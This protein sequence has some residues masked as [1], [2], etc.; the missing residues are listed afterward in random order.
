[1]KHNLMSQIADRGQELHIAVRA[2]GRR[3]GRG[4]SRRARSREEICINA[5]CSPRANAPSDQL[6]RDGRLPGT[7]APTLDTQGQER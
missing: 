3:I 4:D 2:T 5:V 1:M 7:A 6:A